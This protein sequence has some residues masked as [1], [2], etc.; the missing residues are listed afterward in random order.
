M[1]SKA[2]GVPLKALLDAVLLTMT[3]HKESNEGG[4]RGKSES[5]G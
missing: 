2:I 1:K 4:E 3:D 5:F